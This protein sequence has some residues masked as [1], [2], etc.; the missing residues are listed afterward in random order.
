MSKYFEG[1]PTAADSPVKFECKY[2]NTLPLPGNPPM[3]SVDAIIGKVMTVHIKDEVLT[4]SILDVKEA[5]PIARCGY[6]PYTVVVETFEMIIPSSDQK[7]DDV[8]GGL[9][10]STRKHR[11][12]D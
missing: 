1:V 11:D 5:K 2:Y 8:L 12:I 9:D 7:G 3:G 10:G 4:N 6:Y